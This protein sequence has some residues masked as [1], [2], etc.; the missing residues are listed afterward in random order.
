MEG[1]FRGISISMG[2]SGSADYRAAC[3]LAE[4]GQRW[5]S[6]A[7]TL[8]IP[9]FFFFC[10]YVQPSAQRALVAQICDSWPRA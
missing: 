1:P 9:D 4:H 5:P 8:R 7:S 3:E 6:V 10:R 2:V